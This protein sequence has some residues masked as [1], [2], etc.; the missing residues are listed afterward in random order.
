MT[1][2]SAM[3]RIEGGRVR[4]LA[5]SAPEIAAEEPVVEPVT[6]RAVAGTRG[7]VPV[8]AGS[9][10]SPIGLAERWWR[11]R[12]QLGMVTFYLFDPQSWR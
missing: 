11:L 5:W 7:R 4:M 1:G 12:E 2:Y 3:A 6:V 8:L 9:T 10:P